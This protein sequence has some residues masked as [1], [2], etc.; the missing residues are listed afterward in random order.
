MIILMHDNISEHDRRVKAV[1]AKAHSH[2]VVPEVSVE[3]GTRYDVVQINLKDGESQRC[4]S[5][6][7]YPFRMDGVKEVIRR[8]PAK[9]TLQ[10][11]GNNHP[12]HIQIGSDII[13]N[14]L[15]CVSVWGQCT[16][17][18]E[19][20]K[21]VSAL[22]DLGQKH[23]RGGGI[24]PRSSAEG[25]RGFGSLGWRLLFEAA[26]DN[27]ME[28]VWTEVIESSD[29]DDVLRERDR[30]RFKGEVVLWIGA[31]NTGCQK[32]LE[33]L[34]TRDDVIV[35]MKNGLHETNVDQLFRRAEFVVCGPMFW[36]E[37][38]RFDEERSKS[39]GNERLILCA[40][41]LQH[42]DTHNSLR[43]YP[44]YDWVTQI[45]ER[46]WVPACFD[47]SHIAGDRKKVAMVLSD[48]LRRSPDV[49]M[50]ETHH[51]PSQ[52]LCDKDQAV[53]PSDI[54]ELLEM[55]EQANTVLTQEVA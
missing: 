26:R 5:L 13:G 39:S 20:A 54:P 19:V 22:A 55:I 3:T 11:N 48:A 44:N 43:F 33:T 47:P 52:A 25:F 30:T 24:K 40:R 49:V 36:D 46:S 18:R 8:T 7:D 16:I 53:L 6:P 4:H 50:I 32:L 10:S 45:H 51:N 9:V 12:H 1:C 41:G 21:T 31:R 27:N 17:D 42:F 29:V 38:G 28:S 37:H 15:P 34:G 35:M 14:G 23:V 2:G